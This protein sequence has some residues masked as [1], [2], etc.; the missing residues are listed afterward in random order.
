MGTRN[1][2]KKIKS[3]R[4]HKSRQPKQKDSHVKNRGAPTWQGNLITPRNGFIDADNREKFIAET[5]GALDLDT[6]KS[7]LE[8]LPNELRCRIITND[9]L[10]KL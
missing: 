1:P 7:V 2:S 6:F 4:S 10:E 5:A 3:D 9:S 8:Y